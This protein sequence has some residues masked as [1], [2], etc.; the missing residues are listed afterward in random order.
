MAKIGKFIR[1]KWS[2]RQAF[3]KTNIK[4]IHQ[5]NKQLA[6]E[7]STKSPARNY[8]AAE[9][10]AMVQRSLAGTV[11]VAKTKNYVTRKNNEGIDSYAIVTDATRDLETAITLMSKNS[12]KKIF[13]AVEKLNHNFTLARLNR[14]LTEVF[15]NQGRTKD[16]YDLFAVS[17]KEQAIQK[18]RKAY[19]DA[20]YAMKKACAEYKEE[21]G[22]F[23]K[24]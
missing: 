1:F 18:K 21:K 13:R 22:D 14:V 11:T 12:K 16:S 17:V 8:S 23:Y 24:N 20:V 5:I 10:T 6:M 4:E 15:D 19:T 3:R 2:M 9:M 7:T